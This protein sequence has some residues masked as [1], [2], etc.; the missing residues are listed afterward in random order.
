MVRTVDEHAAAIATLVSEALAGRGSH[1]V[2]VLPARLASSLDGHRLRVLAERVVTAIDLPP[3][4]N[5]QMDGYAVRSADLGAGGTALRVAPRIPAGSWPA[6]LEP[7]W[8]AP[9]MTGAAMPPGADAVVPIEQAQPD[10]FVPEPVD[11][12]ATVALPGAPEGLFVRP[13]GSD[14]AAGATLFEAGTLLGAAQ[15]GALAAA[16]VERVRLVDRPRIL[17]VST[18]EELTEPGRPLGPGRIYDANGASLAVALSG[19]GAEVTAARV[20]DDADALLA[21]IRDG[22]REH[23]FDLVVTMGGVSAGAYEVVRDA[24]E[25]RGVTFGSVAMQ[26]GGPQGWGVLDL[27]EGSVPVVGFPGNPVSVLVSWEAFLRVPLLE[28]SGRRA[29]RRDETATLAEGADSPPGK[30]QMRRGLRLGDGRIQ[31]VGGPSSHLLHAYALSDVLVHL[32]LGV[33]RVEAGD[34]VVVWPLDD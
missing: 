7:G 26:P 21:L 32:P 17:L 12:G 30:H 25:T 9:V 14:L 15:W 29:P 1:E 20:P 33:S 31:L 3:F 8:A 6:P 24:F 11:D 4:D 5:S 10:S 19:A 22:V 27:G 2:E 28:A 23:A 16:G 34:E 18:G 13:R